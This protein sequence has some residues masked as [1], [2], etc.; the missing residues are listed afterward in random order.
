MIGQRVVHLLITLRVKLLPMTTPVV[1]K[2][3]WREIFDKRRRHWGILIAVQI[4]YAVSK[5]T[6]L[7]DEGG[8]IIIE[9]A[10]GLVDF[11]SEQSSEF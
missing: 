8:S 4:L 7:E 6:L 10:E 11:A 1:N 5:T 9:M 3:D 2:S